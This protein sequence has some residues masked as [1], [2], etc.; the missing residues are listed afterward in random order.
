MNMLVVWQAS[1]SVH[2]FSRFFRKN[3]SFRSLNPLQNVTYEDI[4]N[5][6]I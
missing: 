5:V 6:G 1:T 3:T 4:M 2:N